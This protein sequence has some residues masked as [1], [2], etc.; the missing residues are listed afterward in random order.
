MTIRLSNTTNLTAAQAAFINQDVKSTASPTFAALTTN[1][2][3]GSVSLTPAAQAAGAGTVGAVIT[4]A[5]GA[6]SA[7]GGAVAG[8]NGGSA[9]LTGGTGGASDGTDAAGLGGAISITAGIGGAASGA[10]AGG[11]GALVRLDGGA[12]GAGSAGAAGGAGGD[13][14][15]NAG[16]GGADGGGGAGADGDVNIASAST[17]AINIGN[18]T[19]NPA[20]NFLGTGLVTLPCIMVNGAI[21]S[22]I[23]PAAQTAGTGT[24][25]ADLVITSGAGA[26]AAGGTAGA[27]GGALTLAAGVGGASDGTDA[28]GTGAAATLTAGAG[29]AAHTAV[30]GGVGANATVAGGAGGAG[31]AGAAGGAGGNAILNA[32]AGGATGG[33][34]AGAD[35]IVQVG[36]EN[37]LRIDIG[38][39]T[40]NP[41]VSILGT[42]DL[43]NHRF[44]Q[45]V[46][47]ATGGTGGATAGTI[48]VQ[49]NTLDGNPVAHAVDLELNSSLVQYAGTNAATGTAFFGAATTGTLN[50]GMGTLYAHVTTDA[51]GLYEGALADAADET[52]YFSAQTASGGVTALTNA[53]V[54]VGVVPDS[55]TWSA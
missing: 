31:S 50:A 33:G 41:D 48:S 15:L 7:A 22:N 9:T 42:G 21:D 28:A 27:N 8:A 14:A 49:V 5:A 6:G 46:I 18:A 38:N 53:C 24:A 32:G 55:A 40:D 13:I 25:G 51:T 44:V 19:D 10:I 36:S 29:G 1:G 11:A 4:A 35:G 34:G 2:V 3:G 43:V 12:G 52:A 23:T 37:T 17:A 30:V 16:A 45:V 20:T 26:A 47:T 39:A 54:V